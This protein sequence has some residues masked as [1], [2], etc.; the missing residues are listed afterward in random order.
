M[1]HSLPNVTCWITLA[2]CNQSRFSNQCMWT[3]FSICQVYNEQI[4]DLLNCGPYLPIREDPQ[5][6]VIVNGL[7]LHKVSSNFLF[8]I[9]DKICHVAALL[10]DIPSPGASW[11]CLVSVVIKWEVSGVSSE[12]CPVWAVRGVRC[13]QWEV[14]VSSVSSE[15]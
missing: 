15:R 10:F 13:E 5:K 2:T 7:S 9:C 12:R 14:A 1:A 11:K 8:I 4:R 6:G 3:S